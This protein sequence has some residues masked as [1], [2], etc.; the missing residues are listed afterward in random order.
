MAIAVPDPAAPASLGADERFKKAAAVSA[1]ALRVVMEMP[2]HSPLEG[3]LSLVSKLRFQNVPSDEQ[4]ELEVDGPEDDGPSERGTMKQQ[5][6]D[7]T[8]A[9]QAVA[10]TRRARSPTTLWGGSTR[11][12]TLRA[13]QCA[14]SSAAA[15]PTRQHVDHDL[16]GWAVALGSSDDER[17]ATLV[18]TAK[19]TEADGAAAPPVAEPT[20]KP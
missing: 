14:R 12:P 8:D 17:G 9:T 15:T 11:R 18:C 5:L 1:P 3:L 6:R 20:T 7:E 2:P 16:K 19:E 13:T 10:S 4:H